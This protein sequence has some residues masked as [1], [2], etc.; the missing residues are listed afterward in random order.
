MSRSK[1]TVHLQPKGQGTETGSVEF[2]LGDHE[3]AERPEGPEQAMMVTP[4]EAYPET[5]LRWP[6]LDIK[7][8]N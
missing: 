6:V 7:L 2:A 3:R 4:L 1:F 8:R 5:L